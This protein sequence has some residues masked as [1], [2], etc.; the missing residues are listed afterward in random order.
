M[1]TV[2]LGST[3][4]SVEKVAN[5]SATWIVTVLTVPRKCVGMKPPLSSPIT[6]VPPCQGVC[7]WPRIG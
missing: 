6:R 1:V 4:T 3:P 7:F 2:L 5:Q